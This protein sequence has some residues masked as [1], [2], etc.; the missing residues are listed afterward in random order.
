VSV[1][2]LRLGVLGACSGENGR[3]VLP[4]HD[5]R[6]LPRM[7][8][9]GILTRKFT[10]SDS[11]TRGYLVDLPPCLMQK[12]RYL[13]QRLRERLGED[14]GDTLCGRQWRGPARGGIDLKSRASVCRGHTRSRGATS[15]TAR[16]ARLSWG[17][18]QNE[19]NVLQAENVCA[20]PQQD[21]I[22]STRI[23][24]SLS[25]GCARDLTLAPL[26]K[27]GHGRSV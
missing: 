8:G 20:L 2:R 7:R 22:G 25:A 21:I 10:S 15:S 3:G 17:R 23:A 11:L 5:L 18:Q 24:T 4:R 12:P 27:S 1:E 9:D 6:R 19:V 13:L 16:A 14:G 26:L